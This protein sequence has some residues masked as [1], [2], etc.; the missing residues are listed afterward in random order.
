MSPPRVAVV[1]VH[2]HGAHHVLAVERR[3]REGRLDFVAVVDP[4]RAPVTRGGTVLTLAELPAFFPTVAA[5]LEARDV[6][7]VIVATP[8]HTHLALAR[9]I[10]A[11]RA[12]VLL[13]KPPVTGR[14]QLAALLAAERAGPG[15][16]QVG[17]QDLGSA[18]LHALRRAVTGGELGAV[19]RIGAWG[20]WS[21]DRAYY[22]RAPWAGRRTVGG[23]DVIDG[24]LTNPFAHAVMGALHVAGRTGPDAIG[25]VELELYHAH[26]IEAD[27]TSSAL[28]HPAGADPLDAGPVTL[29]FTL[30]GP[31]ERPPVIEVA[32]TRLTA[33]LYY[34]EDRLEVADARGRPVEH[35][36]GGRYGRTDL[37]DDLLAARA[38]AA[39]LAAP[40]AQTAGFVEVL[41]A[42]RAADV[43]PVDPRFV[44][45]HGA[46]ASARPQLDGVEDA[47]TR[48][49]ARQ[50]LFGAVGAPWAT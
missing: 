42:V 35:P 47:I 32:G 29:A 26:D 13:E 15:R 37:L 24:T 8:P 3:A 17:F 49:I 46:A 27:D 22:A 40:L 14:D 25:A 50:Q 5:L 16:V 30:A 48:V 23:A 4:R 20:V 44:R 31:A 34:T 12:D 38:G 28:V 2:G 10:L 36:L 21:R 45:W 43:G 7:V 18:A 41:E 1:G 39:P 11:A 6:D 33:R 9:Q 19:R